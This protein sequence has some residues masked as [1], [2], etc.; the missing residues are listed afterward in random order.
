MGGFAGHAYL[1]TFLE[2]DE[3][4]AD[5]SFAWQPAKRVKWLSGGYSSMMTL[6]RNRV[7]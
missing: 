2:G 7:Q 4:R 1:I 6:L 5:E 3:V